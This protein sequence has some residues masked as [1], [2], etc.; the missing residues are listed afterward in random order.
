MS[1]EFMTG[2]DAGD[3]L[4]ASRKKPELRNRICTPIWQD[5]GKA[6]KRRTPL[7]RNIKNAEPGADSVWGQKGGLAGRRT[8]NLL[9]GKSWTRMI[10]IILRRQ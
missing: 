6:G 8:Q 7:F 2:G 9:S 10:S 5:T 3:I 1:R 4:N